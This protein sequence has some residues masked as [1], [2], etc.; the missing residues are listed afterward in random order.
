MGLTRCYKK[1]VFYIDICC[2][3]ISIHSWNTSAFRKQTDAVWKFY[4][5]FRFGTFYRHRHVI[6]HRRN[7]FYPN[8]TITDIV[9]MLRRFSKMAAI[10]LQIYFRFLVL[11][12]LAFRKANN[13][14]RTKFLPDI[15]IHRQ[16]ITTSGCGKQ[17]SGI[18]KFYS[19]F[20]LSHL[21][22]H[23]HVILH[24]PAKFCAVSLS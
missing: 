22:R 20:R 14:L 4:F 8:W 13:Y 24:R 21:H 5:R 15:S 9:M 16:D 7:K 2:F 23:R 10:P 6:L 11:W 19:R 18:F 12:R 17:T 1:A 3:S